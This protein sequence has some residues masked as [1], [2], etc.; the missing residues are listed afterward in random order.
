MA[1]DDSVPWEVKAQLPLQDLHRGHAQG[2]GVWVGGGGYG[3]VWMSIDGWGWGWRLMG[4]Y[5]W[6]LRFMEGYRG[7]GWG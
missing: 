3:G 4:G 2:C 5:G 6:G 1:A 7:E